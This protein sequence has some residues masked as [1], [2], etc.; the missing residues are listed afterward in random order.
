MVVLISLCMMAMAGAAVASTAEPK[1]I[2]VFGDSLSAGFG[3]KTGEA[4][5]FL[6]QQRLGPR[7]RVVNAS[8][9]GET[10]AGGLTRLPSALSQHKPNI[11][12]VELGAND[13]LRGLQLADAR[14][15]LARMIELDRGAGASTVLVAMR[16]PPNFGAVYTT[17]FAKMFDELATQYQLPK[18]PFLFDGLADKPEL[19][20]TDQL[21]PLAIAQGRLLDNVWQALAPLVAGK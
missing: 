12:I 8:V 10:T 3:L 19:F 9:S 16:M 1:T 13:G 17:K 11:V 5:P 2:L 6:L 4:W 7:W 15:N 20:Q 18:P 21:H 14:Q